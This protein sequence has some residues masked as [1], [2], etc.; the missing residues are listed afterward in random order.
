MKKKK[1]NSARRSSSTKAAALQKI[2]NLLPAP[3]FVYQG[4]KNIL[5][6]PAA[7]ALTGYTRR[8]LL[9]MKYWEVVHPQYR[10]LIKTRG[11]ARQHGESV[12]TRY[13]VK[14][15]TKAGEE[16]WLDF[17]GGLIGLARAPAV[18]GAA[19]DIT[20]R[21]Q[22]EGRL[23]YEL[24]RMAAVREISLAIS[25]TLD[26]KGVLEVLLREVDLLLPYAATTVRLQNRQTGQL[27]NVACRN[28]N[29]EEW[30]RGAG[31]RGGRLAETVLRTKDPFAIPNL[32][33]AP[34]ESVSEFFRGQGFVSYLGVPLIAKGEVVGILSFFTREEHDFT[35]EEIAFLR[36]LANQAA[37]AIHNSQ[38]Y[39]AIRNQA[40]ELEEINRLK[41]EFLGFVSHELRTPL[42]AVIGYTGMVQDEVFG[43]ATQEQKKV[44]GKVLENGKHL[45]HMINSLLEATR[46]EVG[47]AK[48]ESRE[49]SLRRLLE[50]LQWAYNTPKDKDLTLNWDYP[51]SLPAIVTD[52]E[53]LKHILQNLVDNAIKFTDHGQITI[54]ARALPGNKAVE[55]KVA[56]T[57][58]GISPETLPDIFDMFR[59][60]I[61]VESGSSA[62]VGLGLHIV[63]KFTHMLGGEIGVKRSRRQIAVLKAFGFT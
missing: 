27:E 25:S 41:D 28:V 60:G 17:S 10:A 26:L 51:D 29:E 44:L 9:N 13:E 6:N 24:Q 20:E 49:V 43:A 3:I 11:A 8:E 48:L 31:R 21:K 42:N 30:K 52:R 34:R 12:P 56:D 61:S 16:R 62:G 32:N 23:Q 55:F 57:G 58:A 38:L 18:V 47:A 54:S 63:K 15:L 50:E 39:E 14:I 22:T 33:A 7:E 4:E 46:I 36:T 1:R 2:I 5:A 59:Q 53:K 35:A 45:L 19:I 40:A 37:V